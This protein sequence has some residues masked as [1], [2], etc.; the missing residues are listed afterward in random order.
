LKEQVGEL[1]PERRAELDL[2]MWMHNIKM[3]A[4]SDYFSTG[5]LSGNLIEIVLSLPADIRK[6]LLPELKES[7][8]MKCL[9]Q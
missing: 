9:D 2:D 6:K 7:V 1:T 3:I 8:V 4:I 5:R